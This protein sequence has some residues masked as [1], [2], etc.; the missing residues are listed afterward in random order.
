MQTAAG[1]LFR[2]CKK[3][4]SLANLVEFECKGLEKIN[5]RIISYRAALE[6]KQKKKLA[7]GLR[8]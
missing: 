2:N 3:N 1:D 7:S 8:K 5:G 6:E 4:D